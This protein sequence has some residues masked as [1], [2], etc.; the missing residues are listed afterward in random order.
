[1]YVCVWVCVWVW[2]WVCGCFRFAPPPPLRY[3]TDTNVLWCFFTPA[4]IATYPWGV[5]KQLAD[6]ALMG[7]IPGPASRLALYPTVPADSSKSERN[8]KPVLVVCCVLCA[9]AAVLSQEQ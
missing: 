6:N 9:D 5:Y 3:L 7:P 4:D 2:V 1:M 8:T